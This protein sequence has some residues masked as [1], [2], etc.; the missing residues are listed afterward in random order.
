MMLKRKYHRRPHEEGL[1]LKKIYTKAHTKK[2]PTRINPPGVDEEA[3]LKEHA[4]REECPTRRSRVREE[5]S[6][7]RRRRILEHKKSSNK[8]RR[9]E[10][11]REQVE[12]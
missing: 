7:T 6:S 10:N 9:K 11:T 12:I 5:Y 2:R 8:L 3:L 4:Y 1:H